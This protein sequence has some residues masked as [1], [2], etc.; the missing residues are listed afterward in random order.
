MNLKKALEETFS[1]LP[2]PLFALTREEKRGIYGVR[3]LAG[4][5]KGSDLFWIQGRLTFW[6]R[7]I[8]LKLRTT[9]SELLASR[10]SWCPSTGTGL[11]NSESF[12]WIPWEE[13]VIIFY[14]LYKPNIIEA[15][16]CRWHRTERAHGH[17]L[18]ESTS[19]PRFFH[20]RTKIKIE[21]LL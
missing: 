10:F 16:Y 21:I 12:L 11:I 6:S 5:T 15:F 4:K 8:T 18:Q 2:L 17:L 7:A 14:V 19:K 20:G 9:D 1:V 13:F 3:L